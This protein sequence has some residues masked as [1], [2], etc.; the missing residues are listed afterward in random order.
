MGVGNRRSRIL[1]FGDGAAGCRRTPPLLGTL[2]IVEAL[3]RA[4]QIDAAA[5]FDYTPYLAAA[6]FLLAITIPLTRFDRLADRTR[7]APARRSGG[8]Q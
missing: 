3:L 7:P 6:G 5:T 2:G 4:A 8:L 1:R